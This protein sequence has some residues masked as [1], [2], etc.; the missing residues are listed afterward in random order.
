MLGKL[1]GAIRTVLGVRQLNKLPGFQIGCTAIDKYWTS[2]HYVVKDFSKEMVQER[3]LQMYKMVGNIV[4]SP[5]PRMANHELF[6]DWV[7]IDGRV[8]SEGT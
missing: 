3:A 8:F 2:N 6:V 4:A 1:L 5:D 7:A